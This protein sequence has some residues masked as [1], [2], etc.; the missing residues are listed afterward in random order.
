LRRRIATARQ[1]DRRGTR[2]CSRPLPS[3][4]S[5]LSTPIQIRRTSAFQR[6]VARQFALQMR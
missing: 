5:C 6:V 3:A 4:H 1:P 2:Y